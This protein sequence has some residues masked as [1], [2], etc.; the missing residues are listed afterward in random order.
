MTWP[1]PSLY[2][3]RPRPHGITSSRS[4]LLPSS[5]AEDQVPADASL[6]A[7]AA[8]F[9]KTL[10]N[11]EAFQTLWESRDEIAPRCSSHLPYLMS[12]SPTPRLDQQNTSIG[13]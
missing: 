10:W 11:D 2:R 8:N 6:E 4:L 9:A 13:S 7:K 12:P 5:S 1:T 3:L